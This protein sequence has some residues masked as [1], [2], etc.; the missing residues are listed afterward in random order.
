MPTISQW[1]STAYEHQRA[2]K[3]L[4]RGKKGWE[5]EPGTWLGGSWRTPYNSEKPT[6]CGPGAL[7]AKDGRAYTPGPGRYTP[8]NPHG[9]SVRYDKGKYARVETTWDAQEKR[10]PGDNLADTNLRGQAGGVFV[11][12][13]RGFSMGTGRG[14]AQT[15]LHEAEKIGQRSA[16]CCYAVSDPNQAFQRPSNTYAGN[17]TYRFGPAPKYRDPREDRSGIPGPG[18]YN[19]DHTEREMGYGNDNKLGLLSTRPTSLAFKWPPPPEARPDKFDDPEEVTPGPGDYRPE[20]C[21]ASQWSSVPSA[22]FPRDPLLDRYETLKAQIAREGRK[23]G[24]GDYRPEQAMD[25]SSTH[26]R[27]DVCLV[28]YRERTALSRLEEEDAGGDMLDLRGDYWTGTPLANGIERVTGGALPRASRDEKNEEAGRPGPADYELYDKMVGDSVA[29][30]IGR[31]SRNA[32]PP[33]ETPGPLLPLV[34]HT[35]HAVWARDPSVTNAASV[36]GVF[37]KTQRG[38]DHPGMNGEGAAVMYDIPGTIGI[39]T[40]PRMALAPH[41]T[42]P[43]DQVHTTQ[44]ATK[45]FSAHFGPSFR[46]IIRRNPPMCLRIAYRRVAGV[47]A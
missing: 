31:A 44:R 13:A 38:R 36:G 2:E 40:D 14:P 25:A 23:L 8:G 9:C 1:G 15:L 7:Q 26:P 41:F 46:Y 10:W 16:G 17:S 37:D 27:S 43:R 22:N 11:K 3:L 45:A 33:L 21:G 12:N 4:S 32:P 6:R 47:I 5:K 42:V 19:V 34:N 18:Y 35:G 39:G 29:W 30:S 24:P 28:A 20:E